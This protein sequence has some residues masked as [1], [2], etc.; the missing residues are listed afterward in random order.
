MAV[1]SGS[2][3]AAMVQ[4][5]TRDLKKTEPATQETFA[6]HGQRHGAADSSMQISSVMV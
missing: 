2:G 6:R 5:R 1:L 4:I 3:T